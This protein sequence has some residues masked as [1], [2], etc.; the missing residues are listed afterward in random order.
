MSTPLASVGFCAR[1]G[2]T[3]PEAK[4]RWIPKTKPPGRHTPARRRGE[5]RHFCRRAKLMRTTPTR[6]SALRRDAA[7][8]DNFGLRWQAQRDTALGPPAAQPKRR[9]AALPAA[10]QNAG[11]RPSVPLWTGGVERLNGGNA[12]RN[13]AAQ[14]GPEAR[15]LGVLPVANRRYGRLKIC[16][17]RRRAPLPAGR[18]DC[19]GCSV[20]HWPGAR[21]TRK[22]R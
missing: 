17:T 1:D 11:E 5:R 19:S 14:S 4:R 13:F 9:G 22:P 6:M 16:A 7:A 18:Q 12:A 10:V 2:R 8:R 21:T 15:A 3:P 20:A